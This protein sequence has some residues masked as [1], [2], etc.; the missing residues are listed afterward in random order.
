MRKSYKTVVQ[1][2]A[3][4]I[5]ETDGSRSFPW[6]AMIIAEKDGDLIDSEMVFKLARPL[7]LKDTSWI[8]P[9]KVSWDWWNAWNVFG[10]D[11]SFKAGQFFLVTIKIDVKDYNL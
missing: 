5:A 8:K 4:Y 3:D 11:V 10:K 1:Q 2:R 9:G 7:R 6:R